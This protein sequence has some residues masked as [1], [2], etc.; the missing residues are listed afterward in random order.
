MSTDH[1]LGLVGSLVT[2]AVVLDM[3]RRQRLREKYAVLWVAVALGVL[4]VAIFPGVLYGAAELVGVEV[5]AHLLFFATALLLLVVSVQHSYELGRLE[6]RSRTL[7]EE[8]ALL[9]LELARTQPSEQEP[10]ADDSA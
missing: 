2:L 10:T 8:V 1:V 3:L 5:P 7:A 9:R 4:V 6:E